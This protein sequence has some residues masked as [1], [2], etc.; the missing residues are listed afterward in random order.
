MKARILCC[1]LLFLCSHAGHAQ[2]RGIA[3]SDT[4]LTASDNAEGYDQVLPDTVIRFPD[5]YGRHDGF[6]LEW[7]YLTAT[8]KDQEGNDLGLQ[9]TLF[10]NRLSPPVK[11]KLEDENDRPKSAWANSPWNSDHIWMAHAA[12]TTKDDHYFEERFSRGAGGEAGATVTNGAVDTW[13]AD[14]RFH[15]IGP[16]Q[17]RL[18]ARTRDFSYDLTLTRKGDEIL[19][20]D[21]G[22][23]VKAASG[24]ASHY[25]SHPFLAVAGTI[26]FADGRTLQVSGD[27]WLDREW[28]SQFL[29]SNQT[30]WEW[31][32]LRLDDGSALTVARVRDSDNGDLIFAGQST[33]AGTTPL[34]GVE[35]TP[36]TPNQ[37]MNW[38]IRVPSLDL[39]LETQ[40]LNANSWNRGLF[41]YFEG[42]IKVSGS[43][44]GVG[45]LEMTGYQPPS[46]DE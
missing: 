43:Q 7:W 34:K 44:K 39:T 45:Y 21:K 41:P 17:Y 33:K 12:I 38:T 31:F 8:L 9:W 28:S 40:P 37:V 2:Q 11:P 35:V 15:S 16:D 26:S 32:A 24:Q 13:L 3:I 23:S 22:Y 6:R 18:S 19:Q 14:W 1:F 29:S 20:G 36:T 46:K 10:R 27:A 42:P 25:F 30:G 4:G 5:D